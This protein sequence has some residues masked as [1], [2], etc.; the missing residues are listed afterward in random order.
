MLSGV[1]AVECKNK[2]QVIQDMIRIG[3]V[4]NTE[5]NTNT[6]LPTLLEMTKLSMA[7]CTFINGQRFEHSMLG[8]I[9]DFQLNN[10]DP[11]LM[12]GITSFEDLGGGGGGR[13][14]SRCTE[15]EDGST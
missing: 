11:C 14:Y 1:N 2:L 3:K 8:K 13:E 10:I 6:T 5:F 12:T 15:A 4:L 7:S 9:P